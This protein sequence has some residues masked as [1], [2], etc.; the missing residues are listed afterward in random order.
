MSISQKLSALFNAA[1]FGLGVGLVEQSFVT[2][3]FGFVV[4][5]N[6]LLTA[7]IINN[8]QEL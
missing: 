6:F 4:F 1:I 8:T 5:L 2:A 3:V 7:W